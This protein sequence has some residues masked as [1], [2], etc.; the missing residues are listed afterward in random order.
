M[1]DLIELL[2]Q[3]DE[4]ALDLL[5]EHYGAYCFC[6]INNLL[7]NEHESEEA[8]SDVWIQVWNSIPPAHPDNLKAYLAK[9]ARNTA[10]NYIKRNS[11][12][13]RS[14]LTITIDELADCLP[15]PKLEAQI[16]YGPL[17]DVLNTFLRSLPEEERRIFIRR[18]WFGD[19]VPQL[20]RK[21]CTNVSRVTGILYRIRKRL[22]RHLE[23][24]GY[25]V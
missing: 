13:S 11:A 14:G 20:A 4:R 12:A 3:R 25:T 19:T 18:Y 9:A 6:I 5:R 1:T 21:F 24:E 15:D 2:Q 10:I 23:Q 16:E 8:L 7:Q 22:K 17:K